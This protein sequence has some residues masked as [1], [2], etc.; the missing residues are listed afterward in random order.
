MISS[1]TIET[2]ISGVRQR[3]DTNLSEH[4]LCNPSSYWTVNMQSIQ[5]KSNQ[6]ISE[7]TELEV[8]E[9]PRPT[10][11]PYTRMTL[12]QLMLMEMT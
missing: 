3:N 4:A 5:K 9:L 2:Q 8:A 10:P 12:D 7:L 1:Q 11:P 6:E